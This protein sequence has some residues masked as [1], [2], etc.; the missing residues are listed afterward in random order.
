MSW[1]KKGDV[2]G[3]LNEEKGNFICRPQFKIAQVMSE[4]ATLVQ[5]NAPT[6]GVINH[7][8]CEYLLPHKIER[9]KK[10]GPHT[11]VF[12]QEGQTRAAWRP[13]RDAMR[14]CLSLA[15]PES[16]GPIAGR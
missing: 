4:N 7:V 8:N 3:L 12:L 2:W 15:V 1:V 5:L 14:V 13:L 11:I 6:F 16:R 10:V 9:V